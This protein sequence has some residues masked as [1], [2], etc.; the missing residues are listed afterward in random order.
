M[1]CFVKSECA[2]FRGSRA[3]IDFMSLV[4]S[5][6][7]VSVG[8]SRVQNFLAGIRGPEI[9]SRGYFVS[10]NFFLVGFL[11]AQFFLYRCFRDSKILSYWLYEQE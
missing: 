3:I 4:P 5:C 11:W 1:V 7:R 9:F 6:H 10:Q 8:I 2:K